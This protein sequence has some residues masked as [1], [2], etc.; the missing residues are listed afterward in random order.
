MVFFLPETQYYRP[1]AEGVAS[2]R[3]SSTEDQ[4]TPG[5]QK[6]HETG[7]PDESPIAPPRKTFVQD[8]RLFSGFNPGGHKENFA[9]LFLRPFPLTIIPAIIYPT[10]VLG[11]GVSILLCL[12]DTAASVFQAPPYLFSPGIQSLM[13][14]PNLVGGILGCLWGGYGTDLYCKY[15]ASKNDG[16]FEPENRL[17]MAIFPGLITAA[18]TLMYVP[19][20]MGAKNS[21]G[22]AVTKSDPWPVA[23]IVGIGFFAFGHNAIPTLSLAY[24]NPPF[25][26]SLRLVES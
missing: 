8:L 4:T 23:W 18:G 15:R 11:I 10:L 21:Y 6:L 7:T 26:H 13:Y 12:V 9:V 19:F 2:L 14:L 24:G 20:V 5:E 25:S 1:T 22:Y 3:S 16:V 17:V